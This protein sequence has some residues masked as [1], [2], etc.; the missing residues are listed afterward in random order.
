MLWIREESNEVGIRALNSH[1]PAP[2]DFGS[3]YVSPVNP[4]DAFLFQLLPDYC[5]Q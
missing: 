5:S 3:V 2:G 1:Q 4:A